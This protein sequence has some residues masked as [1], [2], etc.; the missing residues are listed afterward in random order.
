MLDM[1][2]SVDEVEVIGEITNLLI[3]SIED[4]NIEKYK[5]S[6]S[7]LIKLGFLNDGN[8]KL[9][10]VELYAILNYLVW[11]TRELCVYGI[12]RIELTPETRYI[13]KN[14]QAKINYLLNKKI[15]SEFVYFDYDESVSTIANNQQKII[16]DR[17]GNKYEQITLYPTILKKFKEDNCNIKMV[18]CNDDKAILI[19]EYKA[20][21]IY[22]KQIM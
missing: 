4:N 20:Y 10:V 2:L 22:Q 3:Q 16:F 13:I 21:Y 6:E 9:S 1:K 7:R 8:N 19:P 18:L 12:G 11:A 5:S 15:A 14:L 17:L